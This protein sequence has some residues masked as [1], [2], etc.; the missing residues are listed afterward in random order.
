MGASESSPNPKVQ[1]FQESLE[2]CMNH[3]QFETPVILP[4]IA[5]LVSNF[6][7]ASNLNSQV[8]T[9]MSKTTCW[10]KEIDSNPVFS[11]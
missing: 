1:E 11:K 2:H 4:D 6:R 7:S 5:P 8:K 3:D 10:P 9:L